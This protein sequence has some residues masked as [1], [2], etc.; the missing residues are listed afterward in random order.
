MAV[1]VKKTENGK[2]TAD[3]SYGILLD[4]VINY[5]WKKKITLSIP[6]IK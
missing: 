3:N 5:Y 6:R 2:I 4:T 1:K